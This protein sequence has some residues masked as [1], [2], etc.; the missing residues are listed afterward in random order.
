YVS[1]LHN[2]KQISP[3]QY[4]EMTSEKRSQADKLEWEP[5]I[6]DSESQGQCYWHSA[7]TRSEARKEAARQVLYAIHYYERGQVDAQR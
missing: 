7:G 4:V 6:E 5:W 2:L 1:I 3:V